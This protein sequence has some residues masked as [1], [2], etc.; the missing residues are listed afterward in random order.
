MTSLSA[1]LVDGPFRRLARFSVLTTLLIVVSLPASAQQTLKVFTWAEYMDPDVVAEFEEEFHAK[2]KFD[3]FESDQARDEQLAA[4]AGRG[5][6]VLLINSTQ[7]ERYGKRG[8]LEPIDWAAISNARHVDP[9]WMN[10]F[11]D[12]ETYAVPYFWGTLGIAYR[13][14]LFPQG[15]DSW[16]DL[17]NPDESLRDKIIM[18]NDSRELTALALKAL[19][20]SANSNIS[21]HL[22]EARDVLMGQRE[23]V[24]QYAY[25]TLGEESVLITGEV[26]AASMYSGDVMTLQ[27]QDENIEYYLPDEGG[28]LWVDY[29]TVAQSSDNKTLAHQF[30]DFINRPGVAARLA[31]WVNY[32]SPNL[33]ASALMSEEYL[34]NS[35]INPASVQLENSGFVQPLAPRARKKVNTIGAE[36][37]RHQL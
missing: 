13:K 17:L 14:D 5:Y 27:E 26:W 2:V 11:T 25:P 34:N 29:F 8:W 21:S 6:D 3:Y 16:M 12:V 23:Y 20:H 33:A 4:V 19:G 32:A 24:T 22:N 28:L 10:A 18:I 36:L 1:L 35:V 37:F 7:V 15:F 9:D 30:L 31:E